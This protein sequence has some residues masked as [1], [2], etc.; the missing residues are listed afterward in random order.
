MTDFGLIPTAKIEFLGLRQFAVANA[1]TLAILV[2][3]IKHGVTAK[4]EQIGI[5]G[6]NGVD[7]VDVAEVSE[8]CIGFVRC[9]DVPNRLGLECLI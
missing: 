9:D 4:H 3:F 6:D 8:L 7:F 5:F 1:N 2:H